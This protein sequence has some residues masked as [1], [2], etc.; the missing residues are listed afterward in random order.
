MALAPSWGEK[1]CA[2]FVI[3]L[4]RD[5]GRDIHAFTFKFKPSRASRCDWSWTINQ[6]RRGPPARPTRLGPSV[7]CRIAGLSLSPPRRA[8]ISCRQIEWDIKRHERAR[9]FCVVTRRLQIRSRL[10]D[11]AH[12]RLMFVSTSMGAPLFLTRECRDNFVAE[13]VR[14]CNAVDDLI[15]PDCKRLWARNFFLR[16]ESQFGA[17]EL[18]IHLTA[19]RNYVDQPVFV[20]RLGYILI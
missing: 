4:L 16:F 13:F 5:A 15:Q 7:T 17:M 3:S 20:F 18:W 9:F 6:G 10:S 1:L 19:F 2:C 14:Q 8:R 11:L 12:V